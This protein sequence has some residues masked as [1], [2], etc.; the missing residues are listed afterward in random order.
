MPP[1][2]PSAPAS[3]APGGGAAAAVRGGL[4]LIARRS[5]TAAELRERLEARF[6]PAA[7]AAALRR[8]AHLG[9]VDDERWAADYAAR[10]RSAE[11]SARAL[12]AE[13]RERGVE[14][15]AASAAVR[16]HDDDAAALAAARRLAR[17]SRGRAPEVRARRLRAALARRGFGAETAARA[18]AALAIGGP[19]E[20]AA[21]G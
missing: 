14:A 18:L 7:A 15:A 16:A 10:R 2:S 12:R 20:D 3:A 4:E 13:L 11:R 19:A 6:G 9:Y 8:L 1:R 17:A 21:A 5:R